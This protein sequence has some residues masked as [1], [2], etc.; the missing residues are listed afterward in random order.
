MHQSE[1]LPRPDLAADQEALSLLG[2]KSSEYRAP[3]AIDVVAMRLNL[4][5]EA[6]GLGENAST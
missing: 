3:V 2:L 1:G 6:A 4:T 5:M